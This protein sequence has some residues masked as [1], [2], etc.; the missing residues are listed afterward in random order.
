MRSVL[1][2]GLLI[3]LCAFAD[4]ATVHRSCFVLELRSLWNN[5][6][7]GCRFYVPDMNH[8]TGEGFSVWGETTSRIG[9][10]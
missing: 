2:L 7:F 5:V 1:A 6:P 8:C 3:T 9:F 4:A 10:C